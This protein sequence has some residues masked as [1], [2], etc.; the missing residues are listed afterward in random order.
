MAGGLTRC[1]V[2][3]GIVGG[4]L[5][6]FARNYQAQAIG[7]GAVGGGIVGDALCYNGQGQRIVP[8]QQQVAG[9]YGPGMQVPPMT[10]APQVGV[11]DVPQNHCAHDP[12]TAPGI[13]SLPGHPMN[14][15]TVCAKPGD[16]NISQ[17]L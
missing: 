12:G 2:L 1:Q 14:G 4:V 10:V 17:W 6:S 8:Q 3:G 7:L 16:T 9:Q 5:G 13:L 15:K 11:P